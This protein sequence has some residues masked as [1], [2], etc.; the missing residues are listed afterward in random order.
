MDHVLL[1]KDWEILPCSTQNFPV[2]E[3]SEA[4]YLVALSVSK[5]LVQKALSL[6]LE[7]PQMEYSS[8]QHLHSVRK[9]FRCVG[10]LEKL[11]RLMTPPHSE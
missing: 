1:K 2:M 3:V 9:R 6:I 8:V 4:E 7:L 10:G 5:K 11:Y